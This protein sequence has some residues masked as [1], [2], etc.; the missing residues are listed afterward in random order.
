MFERTPFG[1]TDR[2]HCERI[3]S[4]TSVMPGAAMPLT[5]EHLPD[6]VVGDEA[7][8]ARVGVRRTRPPHE[9]TAKNSEGR[10]TRV[11]RTA[12]QGA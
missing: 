12:G 11:R 10:G 4:E 2:V 9:R 3:F 8:V 1:L 5:V 7:G 6:E